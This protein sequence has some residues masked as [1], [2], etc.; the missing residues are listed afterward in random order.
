MATIN[1]AQKHRPITWKEIIGNQKIVEAIRNRCLTKQFPQVL[2]LCGQSG[3]GKSTLNKLIAMTTKCTHIDPT[4]GDPCGKCNYCTDIITEQYVLD[5]YVYNGGNMGVDEVRELES[6]LKTSSMMSN[7]KV[8]FI[9]EIQAMSNKPTAQQLLLTLIEKPRK[10]VLFILGAM[11]D[12]KVPGS[13]QGRT[14]KYNLKRPA[15]EE[16][17]TYLVNICK[18][19]G[20]P[21]IENDEKKLEVLMAIADNCGGSVRVATSYLENCIVD[22]IWSEK[23]LM[24]V[25][26]IISQSNI[27]DFLGRIITGDTSCFNDYKVSNDI[28]E[29]MRK[30]CFIAYKHQC[31]I[32]LNYYEKQEA[33]QIPNLEHG[34][35]VRTLEALNE[36]NKYVY[37]TYETMTYHLI[38]ATVANAGKTKLAEAVP[39]RNSNSGQSEPVVNTTQASSPPPRAPR[40]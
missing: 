39:P 40:K 36:L 18:K 38:K 3:I 31:G 9:D 21:D 4:T 28:V 32:E 14:V 34:R 26:G 16:I 12:L 23:E 24:E 33:G 7:F 5:N 20:L 19:E 30:K 2:Y 35:T 11:D 17:A 15:L 27:L 6:K 22:N 13:L 10:N 25:V 37:N 1:L 29:E 8:I